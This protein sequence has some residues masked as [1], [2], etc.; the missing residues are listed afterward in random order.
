MTVCPGRCTR[1][2][3]RGARTGPSSSRR[4]QWRQACS[5]CPR[6]EAS[7]PCSRRPIASAAKAI[8]CWPEFLPG[9]DA[10]LFTITPANGSH[11]ER[12]DCGAGSADRHVEGAHPWRQPR[13]L[14]A[15]GASCLRRHRD[16]ARRGLRPRTAG[17]SRDAWAGARGRGD[18][19][20]RAPP[21]SRWR[22]TA[23]SSTSQ[24]WPAAVA[25]RPSCRWI[26]RDV[27]HRCLASRRTRT[28]T[29]ECRPM[30]RGSLW[31]PARC[32]DRTI[33]RAQ[34]GAG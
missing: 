34:R 25:G 18:D 33:S 4:T 12:A 2:V 31:R 7:P 8:T 13:A 5:A 30:A 23:R 24:A 10:V 32:V 29:S 26:A 1:A 21:M 19:R 15:D 16:V 14:R 3:P 11:R 27:P 9:G 17:G 28:A 20:N 22:P 6:Q